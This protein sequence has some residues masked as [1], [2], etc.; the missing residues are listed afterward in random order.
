MMDQNNFNRQSEFLKKKLEDGLCELKL[1]I[2]E[3]KTALLISFLELLTKWNRTYNLTAIQDTQSMVTKHLLDSLSV[4]PFLRGK[5]ILDVGS[6]AGLPGL[7]IAIYN[8]E[9]QVVLL[10]SNGKKT[11]FLTHVI[12]Q[13][14]L[15]N[16]EVVHDRVESFT[17]DVLFDSI[18]ARAFSSIEKIMAY[19]DHLLAPHGRLLIMKGLYPASELEK[20]SDRVKVYPLFV[21]GLEEQ[22]HLVCIEGK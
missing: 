16:V 6:G 10:D 4:I 7:P 13:L 8:P 14:N 2:S 3:T 19:T 9:K 21:P 1:E 5:R 17:A 22:R 15:K 20:I 18:L 11:R 12:G